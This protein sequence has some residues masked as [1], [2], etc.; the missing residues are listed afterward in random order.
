M[1]MTVLSETD[2]VEHFKEVPFYKKP[3]EKQKIKQLKNIDWLVELPFYE[4]L[5]VTKLNQA[6]QGY[7]TSN[8]VELIEKKDPI[9]QLEASKWSI[10]DVF[11]DLL[12]EIKGFKYQITV[13][14]LLKKYK[15]NGEIECAPVYFNSVTKL[16]I[17]H[18]FKLEE[19]FQ[20]I[21]Y[22]ID[23]WINNGSGWIIESIES[24]DINISTYWPLLGRTYIDLS[25]ELKSPRKGLINIK[26]IKIKDAFYGVML[27]ILIRQ[28]SMQKELKKLIKDLLVISVMMTLSFL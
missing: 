8:K 3:I 26:K 18:R 16:V 22:M 21:L 4:Q 6:F 12:N 24:Q 19:S 11:S 17:N 1:K 2:T 20:E 27:G 10:K 9:V 13:Q 5:S 14:V 15:P 28:K 7:A 25:I 23:A